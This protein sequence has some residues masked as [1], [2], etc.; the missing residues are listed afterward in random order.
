MS[1]WKTYKQSRAVKIDLSKLDENLSNLWVKA[2]PTTAHEPAMAMAMENLG[3]NDATSQEQ[4]RQIMRF[5]ILDWNLP[6]KD[7]DNKILP[8]PSEENNDWEENI[9]FD[10]QLFI[11]NEIQKADS[12]RINIPKVNEKES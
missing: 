3:N 6:Y 10:V 7:D 12:E 11:M 2:L 5:W 9:P 8:I 4:N 1:I